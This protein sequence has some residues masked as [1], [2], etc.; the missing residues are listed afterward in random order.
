LPAI[1]EVSRAPAIP[2]KPVGDAAQ[3]EVTVEEV[4]DSFE[5][6]AR[7]LARLIPQLSS[8]SG[9]PTIAEVEEM[10]TSPATVLFVAR[11]TKG[12]IVGS[13]TLALFRI[14]TGIRAW[15]EDVVVDSDA[16][17]RGIGELLVRA[18]VDK[19]AEM[20][21][22][23]VDLTSRPSRQDANRLYTNLG[24]EARETNVYRFRAD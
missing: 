11:E 12:R 1:P 17:R 19:A 15:I 10:A 2:P 21:A 8:S 14:P 7:A 6:V 16:R 24:F 18:A 23:T 4:T 22:R 13:L 3:E 9:P 20:G 5:D